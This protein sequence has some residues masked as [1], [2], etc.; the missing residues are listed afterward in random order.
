MD[1]QVVIRRWLLEQSNE[2]Q[3]LLQSLIDSYFYKGKQVLQNIFHHQRF[4]YKLV[5]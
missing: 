2:V 3:K 5:N 4:N 1:F